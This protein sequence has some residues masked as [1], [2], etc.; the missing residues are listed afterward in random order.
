MLVNHNKNKKRIQKFKETG[1]SRYIYRNELDKAFFQHD[2]AYEG[3]KDLPRR[4]AS[5]NALRDEAFHIARNPK[6]DG[7]DSKRSCFYEL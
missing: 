6:Y 3:F 5:Y 1:N 4:T 7:H 2:I